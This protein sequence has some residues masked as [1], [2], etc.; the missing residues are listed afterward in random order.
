MNIRCLR[1]HVRENRKKNKPFGIKW[2]LANG[3][4]VSS[5]EVFDKLG[6]WSFV[7]LRWLSSLHIAI[8]RVSSIFYQTSFPN[9]NIHFY[10]PS[11]MFA[12]GIFYKRAKVRIS[13]QCLSVVWQQAKND[14]FY[15]CRQ[16]E[17]HNLN[18]S[19]LHLSYFWFSQGFFLNLGNEI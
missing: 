19:V 11:R 18:V 16:L 14:F 8:S 6:L 10:P 7:W 5:I 15:V 9:I 12:E 13:F 4:T 3:V 2:A 17:V 1:T